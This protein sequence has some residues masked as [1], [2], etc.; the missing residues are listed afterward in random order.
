[1]FGGGNT[2]RMGVGWLW[3][4][5]LGGIRRLGCWVEVVLL[6]FRCRFALQLP[7]ALH[8]GILCVWLLFGCT[9]NG[10]LF[11]L[12]RNLCP[13]PSLGRDFGV[14]MCQKF[15]FSDRFWDFPE[16]HAIFAN[17]GPKK[18]KFPLKRIFSSG[19]RF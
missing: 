11:V 17:F 4:W 10:I 5:N 9:A 18:K 3:G 8:P 7:P 14:K 13:A 2:G 15:R 16:F 12:K 19:Q 6:E 1:M